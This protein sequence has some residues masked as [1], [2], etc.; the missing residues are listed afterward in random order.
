ME[1]NHNNQNDISKISEEIFA[2]AVEAVAQITYGNKNM[3]KTITRMNKDRA[4]L[5]SRTIRH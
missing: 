3:R 2:P 5:R 4:A 1:F